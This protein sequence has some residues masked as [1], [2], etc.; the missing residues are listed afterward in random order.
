MMLGI[1]LRSFKTDLIG[2]PLVRE[3]RRFYG[4][5]HRH[6]KVEHIDHDAQEGMR[7]GPGA[8]TAGD[9]LDLAILGYDGR[10]H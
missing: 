3:T 9:Q 5:L 1:E 10:G 4:R 8:G 2:K 6:S 7:N